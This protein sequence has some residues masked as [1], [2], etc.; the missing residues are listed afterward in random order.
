[1]NPHMVT[2]FLNDSFDEYNKF[3]KNLSKLCDVLKYND[4]CYKFHRIEIVRDSI[5]I[6]FMNEIDPKFITKLVEDDISFN[7]GYQEVGEHM[8]GDPPDMKQVVII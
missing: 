8:C 2:L 7:V 1:M 5:I 4:M 6:S 3:T